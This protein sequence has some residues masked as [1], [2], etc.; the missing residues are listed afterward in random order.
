MPR[1]DAKIRNTRDTARKPIRA[2]TNSISAMWMMS[3]LLAM[4]GDALS[5]RCEAHHL[6]SQLAVGDWL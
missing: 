1:I 6:L 5:R 4:A 2:S 3:T